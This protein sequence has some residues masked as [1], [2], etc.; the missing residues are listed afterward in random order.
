[1]P[2]NYVRKTDKTAPSPEIL[3][4]A[5][6]EVRVENKFVKSVVAAHSIARTSFYRMLFS[7][8]DSQ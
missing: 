7:L 4:T 3:L 1:M 8:F 2:R 5:V 6:K